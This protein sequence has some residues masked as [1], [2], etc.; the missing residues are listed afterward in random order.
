MI[1]ATDIDAARRQFRT[2]VATRIV[3]LGDMARWVVEH[4]FAIPE[5]CPFIPGV[6]SVY[7]TSDWAF[8]LLADQ[9][10]GD[11]RVHREANDRYRIVR[12]QF[13]TAA[14]EVMQGRF[15]GGAS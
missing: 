1:D 15:G 6:W 13:G 9:L 11:G 14:L 3:D 5:A 8:D 4:N 10:E 12:R 7:V 2:D